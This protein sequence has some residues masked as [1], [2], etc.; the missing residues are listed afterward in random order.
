M[1]ANT[2][3]NPRDY[4]ET[5]HALKYACLAKDIT[6]RARIDN[7]APTTIGAKKRNE[8]LKEAKRLEED[9]IAAQACPDSGSDD[10]DETLLDQ[11]YELKKELVA[12]EVALSELES[13]LR[14]ELC[15]NAQANVAKME[16]AYKSQ[17]EQERAIMEEKYEAKML[18]WKR[19]VLFRL[20]A[21]R[22]EGGLLSKEQLTKYVEDYTRDFK[23][24]IE[25]KMILAVNLA[26]KEGAAQVQ[27]LLAEKERDMARKVCVFGFCIF[28]FARIFVCVLILFCNCALTGIPTQRGTGKKFTTSLSGRDGVILC[29]SC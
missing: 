19:E 29:R 10:D 15:S 12:K 7:K 4:D 26:R 3:S 13:N 25:A 9:L 20:N 28:M 22:L 11:I 1:I 24:S 14:N 5:T 2:S 21:S 8:A 16:E 17:L 27:E 23:A 18:L 6:I